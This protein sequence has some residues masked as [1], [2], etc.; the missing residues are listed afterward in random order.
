VRELR[1]ALHAKAKGSPGYRFYSLYDKVY[2][3]DVLTVA[4][5][6]CRANGGAAGTDR[7]RFEDIKEYG[8]ERWLGELAQ[9]LKEKRYRA[10]TIRRVFIPKP[11]GKLRP[12]GIS[13]IRDRW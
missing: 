13:P 10:Q 2:R 7:Q 4:Y 1:A 5:R 3:A 8:E 12:L 11:N 6:R 9:E